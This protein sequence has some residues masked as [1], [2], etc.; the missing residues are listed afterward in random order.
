M[1]RIELR[2]AYKS[3]SFYVAMFLGLVIALGQYFENVLPMVKYLDMDLKK[4]VYP[5]S[6]FN[7]WLGGEYYTVWPML[8]YFILPV[9]AVLPYGDSFYRDIQTGY[10][11][12][13][14]IRVERKKYLKAKLA[15]VYL[16]GMTTVMF[17]LVL[18]LLLSAVTLPALVPA[19]STGF[20]FIFDQN[21]WSELF[22]THP[23]IYNIIYILLDGLFGGLFACIALAGTLYVSG[24]FVATILPFTVQ[25]TVYVIAMNFP[26]LSPVGF[27]SPTQP[28]GADIRIILLEIIAMTA[29]VY[30][31][32]YRKGIKDEMLEI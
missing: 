2:R 5:H 30:L 18:N 23:W 1:L 17:P 3:K 13:I 4:N 32:Y 19:P 22:L 12:N 20:F 31:L 29:A 6:I 21:M 7:K 11:K 14:F 10:I 28:V 15:A 25:I 8:F 16:T 27:L 9:I 24:R 26:E